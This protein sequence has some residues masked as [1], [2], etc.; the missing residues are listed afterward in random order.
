[1]RK[2]LN[3][4]KVYEFVKSQ[5]N[6]VGRKVV[7]EKFNVNPSTAG[8]C[9]KSLF[10]RKYLLDSW[11]NVSGN[12]MVFFRVSMIEP[13]WD[14]REENNDE[15]KEKA[16]DFLSTGKFKY[17]SKHMTEI[18]NPPE[19]CLAVNFMAS[20]YKAGKCNRVIIQEKGAKTA[21]Y[22]IGNEP[23]E[24]YKEFKRKPN[25]EYKTNR[26]SCPEFTD[27]ASRASMRNIFNQAMGLA[28]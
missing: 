26:L 27:L 3:A 16:I 15:F 8:S 12:K 22:F 19:N 2:K 1:M 28:L 21:Y 14:F 23:A 9:L 4:R 6:P 11:N 18:L 7:A 20:I 17:S 5:P 10:K 13:I 24:K 25:S